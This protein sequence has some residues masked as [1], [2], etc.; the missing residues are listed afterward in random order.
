LTKRSDGRGWWVEVEQYL[1]DVGDLTLF[2][3]YDQTDPNTDV[4]D[5]TRHKITGGLAWPVEGWHARWAVELRHIK[6]EGA[7]A[8]LSTNEAVGELMINF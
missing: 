2:A 7:T 8:D 5:N 1:K 3:R 4:S 6:Q